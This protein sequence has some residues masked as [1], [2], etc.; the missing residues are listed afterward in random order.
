MA[1]TE[2]C[3]NIDTAYGRIV[4]WV[5][6]TTNKGG[7]VVGFDFDIQRFTPSPAVRHKVIQQYRQT[8]RKPARKR[9]GVARFGEVLEHP[10]GEVNDG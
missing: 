4:A 1:T 7:E 9:G 3:L 10:F 8:E 2:I 6:V 5:D